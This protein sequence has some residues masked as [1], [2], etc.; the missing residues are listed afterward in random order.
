VDDGPNTARDLFGDPIP[1]AKEGRKRRSVS[2]PR[3]PVTSATIANDINVVRLKLPLRY[4]LQSVLFGNHLRKAAI[5]TS[6]WEGALEPVQL[7][8]L[9]AFRFTTNSH[10]TLIVSK[11]TLASAGEPVLLVPGGDTPEKIAQGLQQGMGVWLSPR[12]LRQTDTIEQEVASL[13]CRGVLDSWLDQFTFREARP[14]VGEMP[15]KKGMRTPQ[16][17]ALHAALAHI[18]SSTDAATIVMPTGT[19]KTETMLAIYAHERISRLMVVV[20]TDA[21]RDQIAS[22]FE[23]FGV[24]Q[25]Q[26]CISETIDYPYVLRLEHIPKSAEEVE[27]LFS[28]A[29]VIVTTMSIAGRAD[30]IVQERMAL[31][32]G[33]L[34]IDEAHHVSAKTWREFRAWFIQSAGAK[35][36]L[37]FTATPFREDGGKVDGK[38]IYYYPLSKAQAEEYFG[39]IRF[40]AVSDLE[41]SEADHEIARRLG[42]TLDADLDAG[43]PHLAMVRCKAI[44]RAEDLHKLYEQSFPQHHPVLVHSNQP[45]A[46]RTRNLDRLKKQESR[47]IVCVDMLGEG[48][49]LPELKIAAIHDVFKSVAVTLQFVGRFSRARTDLGDATVIANTDQDRLDRAL[50]KL[51]AEEADWNFLIA[52]ISGD[53]AG[54]EME[55]AAVLAGFTGE[56]NE[57]PLQTIETSLNTYVFKV[58]SCERW[59]PH[60]IEDVVPT[61]AFIGMK[62]NERERIAVCVLRHETQAKWTKSSV[63]VDTNW[64]L[65]LAHWD[66]QSEMLYLSSTG[67]SITDKMAKAVCGEETARIR[68]QA[69]FRCFHDFRQLVIRNLGMTHRQGGGTRYSML[70]GMDVSDG[71]DSLKRVERIQNNIFGSGFEEGEPRTLGCSIKGKFW[72]QGKIRDLTDW[73]GWCHRIGSLLENEAI[74]TSAAFA[75]AMRPRQIAERPDAHPLVIHWPDGVLLSYEER[76]EI[77]FGT[78]AYAITECDL[79]LANNDRTGPLSFLL[80]CE[81]AEAKFEIEFRDN[82]A[83]YPQRSGPVVSIKTPKKHVTLSEF[84]SDDAP[85]IDFGDGAFLIY[86]HLYVPPVD[87]DLTPILDGSI[88][89]WDWKGTNLRV[90]SQG[91]DKRADSVQFR[92]IEELKTEDFD[93]IFNDDGTGEFADVIAMRIKENVVEIRLCHCKYSSK[94]EPGAR[95]KD[96]YEVAGQA[97]K[98]VQFCHKPK[99]FLRNMVNREKRQRERDYPSR[100][101]RGTLGLLRQIDAKREQYRF[102][103]DV[104]IVQ[105]GLSKAALTQPMLQLLGFVETALREHRRI[106][107]HAVVSA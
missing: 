56:L 87:I 80:R 54:R 99:R 4:S 82:Q 10:T 46:E 103:Y 68:D 29:N 55:R 33:A 71:L 102:S 83:F 2:Q 39:K 81:D 52:N 63:A 76:V 49:D 44:K 8:K 64:E 26:G 101:E 67:G 17:G 98:S 62:L 69:V 43:R 92:V 5:R 78:K 38:F 91:P 53:R 104:W 100:F 25:D 95:L 3:N 12:P 34:F 106:P 9:S 45:S 75:S 14:A 86:S 27:I 32:C 21:L 60:R 7:G 16:I 74:P 59:D 47:V 31:L 105:P 18:T 84:F 72:S 107:L 51:Y 11:K 19:G 40:H 61:G 35:L 1:P 36:I 93:I 73:T 6:V 79:L 42:A 23:T 66:E 57:I 48:F 94:D 96:L 77:Q 28:Q 20:P 85:Q 37:Q 70:M 13:Q 97:L 22:K 15:S 90:E 24:L 30:A 88:Q 41:G 58:G 89:V 50:A 65:V